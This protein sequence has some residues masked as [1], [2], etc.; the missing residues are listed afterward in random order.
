M[1]VE[2]ILCPTDF[3]RS[4]ASAQKLAVQTAREHG[5]E[6]FLYHAVPTHSQD[7][8]A[9]G[10][11][12]EEFLAEAEAQSERQL[13]REVA[14][15]GKD[16]F[17]KH[18]VER[19]V[20]A[21]NGIL[22]Q[23]LTFRPD[24]MIVATHAGVNGDQSFLGTVSGNVIRHAPC[25]VWTV[26]PGAKIPEGDAPRSVLVPVDFSDGARR[27]ID[28]A[29]AVM[30]P[31]D[32]LLALHVLHNP[33]HGASYD[34]DP[35]HVFEVDIA[36]RAKLALEVEDWLE[37]TSCEVEIRE[38]DVASIILDVARRRRSDLV[39]MGTRGLTGVDYLMVGS[40]AEKIVCASPVPVVVA[41]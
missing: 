31:Q 3:S 34:G 41:K 4:A 36:L 18:V 27:A 14:A 11:M 7:T 35:V 40:V 20:N 37:G 26:R 19:S 6:L 38:G 13:S 39:V 17:V 9:L 24:L 5:A 2:R 33:S 16:V 1:K 23:A 10:D 22:A 30:R 12:L 28:V 25:S 32:T 8:R 21:F 29:K 15:I